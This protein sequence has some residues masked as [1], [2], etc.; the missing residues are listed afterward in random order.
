MV[1]VTECVSGAISK[2]N[3]KPQ[4]ELLINPSPKLMEL[5]IRRF[6]LIIRMA[7]I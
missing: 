6:M 1:A 3:V 7:V 2:K 5:I 4:E